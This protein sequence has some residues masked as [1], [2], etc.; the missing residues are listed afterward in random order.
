[1]QKIEKYLFNKKFNLIFILFLLYIIIFFYYKRLDK[2]KIGYYSNSIRYGG[3][4]RVTALLINLLSKEK[5]FNIYLITRNRKSEGEY[6]IPKK[7]KKNMLI[8]AK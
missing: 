5:F 2:I 4:E 7:Y 6:K 3:V 1:V 8:R